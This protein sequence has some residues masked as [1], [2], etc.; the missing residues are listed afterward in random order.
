MNWTFDGKFI[1]LHLLGTSPFDEARRTLVMQSSSANPFPQLPDSGVNPISDLSRCQVPRSWKEVFF[2]HLIRRDTH[3]LNKV[4]TGTC[5]GSGP[6]NARN[7]GRDGPQYP[8]TI[9]LS[10]RIPFKVVSHIAG[11]RRR[12]GM[13][14]RHSNESTTC[15]QTDRKTQ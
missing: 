1:Y 15:G 8:L 6:V 13:R 2:R 12:V 4:S 3:S 5:I 14:F 11:S 9:G 7:A 10:F